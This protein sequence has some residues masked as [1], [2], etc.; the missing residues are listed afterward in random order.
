ML[1]VLFLKS[2]GLLGC[3]FFFLISYSLIGI[4]RSTVT[5]HLSSSGRKVFNV[6]YETCRI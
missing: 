4:K 3:C 2:A 1:K 6:F 5:F